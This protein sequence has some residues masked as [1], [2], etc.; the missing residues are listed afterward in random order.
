MKGLNDALEGKL[1]Q[2]QIKTLYL[3]W[4]TMIA[5]CAFVVVITTATLWNFVDKRIV[6]AWAI[7]NIVFLAFRARSILAEL[8]RANQNVA[9]ADIQFGKQAIVR[10]RFYSFTNSLLWGLVPLLLFVDNFAIFSI[11]ALTHGGYVAAAVSATASYDL[12]AF[13]AFVFPATVLWV[14]GLIVNG[15]NDYLIHSVL[16]S[17]YPLIMTVFAMRINQAFKEQILLRLENANLNHNLRKQ[18]DRAENAMHEKNRFLAAASHDLRQPVH[19]LGLF[20]ASLEAY[21]TDEKPRVLL[22]K[23]RQT[24]DN[25]GSLFHSLLDL[26][27]LDADVVQNHPSHMTIKPLLNMLA[28]EYQEQADRKQLSIKV[29]CPSGLVCYVDPSLLERILRNLLSNAVN[30]TSIGGVILSAE[31][32]DAAQIVVRCTDT[33]KGIP[34][35]EQQKIFS[36]YHQLENPER[37]RKKG[38]GLGLAIVRRLCD[39]MDVELKLDSR[40]GQGSTF[41]LVLSSGDPSMVHSNEVSTDTDGSLRENVIVVDDEEDILTGMRSLLGS[42]G[43]TVI[44]AASGEEALNSLQS[45]PP[46]DLIIADFRL[47]NHESGLAVIGSIRDHVGKNLPAILITGDTA[48]ERLQQAALADVE[49][50]HKPV[51]PDGL[52]KLMS[53]ISGKAH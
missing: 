7:A 28:S 12:K 26:S 11:A 34:V 1:Q 10:Y 5:G 35:E 43:C 3:Q 4:K 9:E 36:E 41:S 52:R 6:L 21:L 19:T 37:D 40:P 48:P 13:Y 8:N 53:S 18:R 47:R 44:T 29:D 16:F 24:T 25:M 17:I 20:V 2:E 32:V 45:N 42:W 50:L 30:H 15:G 23:I 33:G 38:L 46:I 14:I 31:K 51:E 27:K 39:L 22:E 49:V